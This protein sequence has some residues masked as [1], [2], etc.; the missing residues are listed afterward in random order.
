MKYT[1]KVQSELRDA[2]GSYPLINM[3]SLMEALL[4]Q[5]SQGHSTYALQAELD[6]FE[7][8]LMD[9]YSN[10]DDSEDGSEDGSSSDSLE[11]GDIYEWWHVG[12]DLGRKLSREGEFVA[13]IFGLHIWGRP[14]TGQ[15]IYLDSVIENIFRPELRLERIRNHEGAFAYIDD[16]FS[17]ASGGEVRLLDTD[18]GIV[19]S[20]GTSE[21]VRHALNLLSEFISK[22]KKEGEE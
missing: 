15:A 2:L 21:N 9:Y 5:A 13:R 20:V 10:S 14:T 17:A 3:S 12:S 18:D 16:M 1:N 7:H 4:H 8:Q 22:N 6:D 19:L 11:P